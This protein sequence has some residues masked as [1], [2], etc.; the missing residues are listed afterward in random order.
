MLLEIKFSLRSILN[1]LYQSYKN[2]FS[3]LLMQIHI[4]SYIYTCHLHFS[5]GWDHLLRFLSALS[6]YDSRTGWGKHIIQALLLIAIFHVLNLREL[7]KS[8]T[9]CL[10]QDV[11]KLS[12]FCLQWH[13]RSWTNGSFQILKISIP[14]SIF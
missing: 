5:S 12:E 9:D 11:D 3:R 1:V 4:L 6:F 14:S 2:V 8:P 7:P 10:G 13:S